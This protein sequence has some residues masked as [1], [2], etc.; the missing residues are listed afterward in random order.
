M[1]AIRFHALGGPEV[2]AP[3]DAPEPTPK[4]GQVKIAVRAVGLNYA[5]TMFTKGQYF[6]RPTFPAIPGLEAAGEVVALGE[7]VTSLRV[8]DRVMALGAGSYAEY[9]VAPAHYVYP[10]PAGL[11]YE[12]AA[13]LPI[14]GLT[15]HHVLSLAGRLSPGEAVLV[16]AAAGGVGSLAVQ[17]ARRMGASFIVGTVGS[18]AKEEL[19]RGLG[20]DLVV[21]Y[22]E[23]D[24]ATRIRNDIKRGVDVALEM[25]GGSE[26]YKRT[27]A[28]LAPLGRMVVFGA[29]TGDVR[30]T[31]EPV[32]LMPKN[33][34]VIGYYL[35]ALLEQRHLCEGP[36]AELSRM[37]LSG[38][39]RVIIGK[40]YRLEE[41]AAAHRDLAGRSSTGK[42]VLLV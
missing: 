1:R 14:Q 20:A 41:A 12:V 33:L 40:T 19:V 35:T 16:H 10:L 31:I 39:L 25:L 28:C 15:A 17:L 13:A 2:L 38:E 4:P 29:A 24:F 22:R 11:S 27:L 8:G 18:T 23:S 9:M 21:N 36:L 26:S 5:D 42:L 30:G 7:G 6:V 37:A 3:E 32:G 34:S